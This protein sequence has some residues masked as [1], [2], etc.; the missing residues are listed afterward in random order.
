[1]KAYCQL[2]KFQLRKQRAVFG[3]DAAIV[4]AQKVANSERGN[5]GLLTP[6]CLVGPKVELYSFNHCELSVITMTS[7]QKSVTVPEDKE[8]DT[9]IGKSLLSNLQN[10]GTNSDEPHSKATE[11]DTTVTVSVVVDA[12]SCNAAV[13]YNDGLTVTAGAAGTNGNVS[14]QIR[15]D[16]K[17]G[18]FLS[19]C[20]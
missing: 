9:L 4:M 3:F 5:A 1:M 6:D 10:E 11:D 2:L 14:D 7:T 16:I 13:I 12:T 18:S 17:N 15:I 8:G 19:C 20:F